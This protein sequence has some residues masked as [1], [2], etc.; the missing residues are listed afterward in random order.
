VLFLISHVFSPIR[1]HQH[2]THSTLEG[3]N[4][5]LTILDA[6]LLT[7]KTLTQELE[8]LS[9]LR[10]FPSAELALVRKE[11]KAFKDHQEQVLSKSATDAG[12]SVGGGQ[13]AAPGGA[14]S[15]PGATGEVEEGANPGAGAGGLGTGYD[16]LVAILSAE[17]KLCERK[18][19]MLGRR[20]QEEEDRRVLLGKKVARARALEEAQARDPA[21]FRNQQRF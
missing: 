5:S 1:P 14:L 7:E 16:D 15:G 17:S 4:L 11:V 18:L 13:R 12:A 3:Q 10:V 20:R 9:E 6:I 19:L 21:N 2:P 8:L